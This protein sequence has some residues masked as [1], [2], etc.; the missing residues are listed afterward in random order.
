METVGKFDCPDCD[1]KFTRQASLTKHTNSM[2]YKGHGTV[3]VQAKP[4]PQPPT[5]ELDQIILNLTLDPAV[6]AHAKAK[7]KPEV[8]DVA[9]KAMMGKPEFVETKTAIKA[10]I[11]SESNKA[12]EAGKRE[13]WQRIY[14][15][16][17]SISPYDK[18]PVQSSPR[19][20]VLAELQT[21]NLN[22]Q[23]KTK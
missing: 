22:E 21:L 13:E 20:S 16:F 3:P 6:L 17:N 7:F 12:K 19:E 5:G 11:K 14:D 8:M 1:R 15:H 18:L 2:W 10:L 4:E 23:E 9:T